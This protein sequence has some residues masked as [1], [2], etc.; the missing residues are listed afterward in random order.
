MV[1]K[2]NIRTLLNADLFH[3]INKL[4]N[5]LGVVQ[6]VTLSIKLL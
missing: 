4:R 5:R 6:G 2:N 1:L 3:F